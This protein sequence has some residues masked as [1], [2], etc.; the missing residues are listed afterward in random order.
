MKTAILFGS[1]GLIGSNL[2]ELLLNKE[3]SSERSEIAYNSLKKYHPD[4][5]LKSLSKVYKKI[6]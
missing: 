4:E 3:E 5:I 1:T 2:L 6:Y